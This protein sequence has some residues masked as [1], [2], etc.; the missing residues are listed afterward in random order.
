MGPP[1]G[2]VPTLGPLCAS[3][4]S[5]LGS[6]PSESS[7]LCSPLAA[8]TNPAQLGRQ[9]SSPGC[10]AWSPSRRCCPDGGGVTPRETGEWPN[11][12][13]RPV[14]YR[15]SGSV[16][17]HPAG[18]AHEMPSPPA[19]SKSLIEGQEPGGWQGAPHP[20]PS[21]LQAF[22]AKKA[23][24]CCLQPELPAWASLQTPF[25][26]SVFLPCLLMSAGQWRVGS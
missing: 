15:G 2:F 3:L 23:L 26:T 1:W 22:Q 6:L 5:F 11:F 24:R 16:S 4:G 21:R 19:S 10:C 13:Q 17:F 25:P 8:F 12:T 9:L 20:R 7:F 14:G 18:P